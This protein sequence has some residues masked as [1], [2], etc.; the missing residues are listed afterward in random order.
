MVVFEHGQIESVNQC[1]GAAAFASV[2]RH[3]HASL[4]GY[5]TVSLHRIG[6]RCRSSEVCDCL[7]LGLHS[8]LPLSLTQGVCVR[9]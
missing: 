3:A 1:G 9:V 2:S 7:S 4:E 6:V 5:A 8:S